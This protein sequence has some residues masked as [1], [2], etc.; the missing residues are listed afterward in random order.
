MSPLTGF[1]SF[2][3]CSV[4]TSTDFSMPRFTAIGFAPAATVFTPS[5]KIACAR[6]VAVVVP[7]PATSLFFDATSFNIWAPR[8]SS[9]SFSSISFAT[10]TPSFVISGEPNFLSRTTLRPFGPSVI[11]TA[12]ARMLTPRKIAWREFSPVTIC[13]AIGLHPPGDRTFHSIQNFRMLLLAGCRLGHSAQFHQDFL[14]AEDQILLVV[15]LDVVAGIFAEQD[16]VTHLYV[17][18]DAM[19]LFHLA[20]SDG[21]Y[22]ALLRLFF[23]RIGDDDPALCGFFLFQPAYEDTVM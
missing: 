12:S 5:R 15:D 14:L 18:R 23:S 10:V 6:T 22:F 9:G 4:A 21:H 11:F 7:S 1:A 17:E 3:I 13:F 19:A 8:F 20:G 2:L 16:P